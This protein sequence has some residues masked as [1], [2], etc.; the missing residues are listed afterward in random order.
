MAHGLIHKP[1]PAAHIN[2]LRRLRVIRAHGLRF[3]PR[4]RVEIPHRGLQALATRQLTASRQRHAQREIV[5]VAIGGRLGV[6]DGVCETV[7]L[8]A[9]F[10]AGGL[11]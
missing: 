4:N 3:I 8:V 5:Y 1:G 10:E 2:H 11:V 6:G 7:L 9:V